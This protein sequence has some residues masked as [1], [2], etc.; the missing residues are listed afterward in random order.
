MNPAVTLEE[1]CRLQLSEADGS[2]CII[3]NIWPVEKRERIGR[4]CVERSNAM[5]LLRRLLLS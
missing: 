1:I 4:S 3:Q 5:G 2:G